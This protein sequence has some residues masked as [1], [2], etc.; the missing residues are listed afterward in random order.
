MTVLHATEP[1]SVHLACWARCREVSVAQVDHALYGT[2][3][4][5]KQLS[6]RQTLFAYPR[7]LLPAAWGSAAARTAAAVERQLAGLAVRAGV[8]EPGRGAEWVEVAQA[9]A[10]AEIERSGEVTARE[11]RERVPELAGR[12][13]HGQGTSWAGEATLIPRV[14]ALLHTRA[15]IARASNDGHWRLSRPRWTPTERWLGEVE[16]AWSLREGYAELVRRWLWTFGPGTVNDLAWWLG[17][18]KA[19]VRVALGD[20]DA[21]AVILD[22]GR[23]GWLRPDD[24]DPIAAPEPW[25]ALLP[26]LDP[27]VMGWQERSFY[28][29]PYGPQLFDSVGNAGTTVWVDGRVVGCWVQDTDQVVRIRLLEPIAADADRMLV[30]EAERLTAWLRGERVFSVYPSPAMRG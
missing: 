13:A 1:A 5:V 2:R 4:L 10:L 9:A 7:E 23:T 29:G 30:E 15:L 26:V 18:T 14:I 3:T 11:L 8:A 22:G 17:A 21:V 25:V 20:V 27:T 16:P 28:L 24:L 19:D 6:M 12:V